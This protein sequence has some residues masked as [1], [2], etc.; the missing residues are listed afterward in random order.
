MSLRKDVPRMLARI[1]VVARQGCVFCDEQV[2]RFL[3]YRGWQRGSS[4]LICAL[5]LVAND[6]DSFECPK[7]GAYDREQPPLLLEVAGLLSL[8]SGTRILHFAPERHYERP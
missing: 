5:G 7:C 2:G 4:S 8:M 1:P 3:P 6:V